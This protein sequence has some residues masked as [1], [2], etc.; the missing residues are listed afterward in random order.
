MQVGVLIPQ[1]WRMDLADFPDDQTKFEAMIR[2]AQRAEALGFESLWLYDHFHTTPTPEDEA[3]FECFTSLA[4]IARETRRIRLGQL[5]TCAWYRPPSLL[6]K[7][8]CTLDVASGGRVELGL[9]AG[10]YEHEFLAYGYG[11]PPL[12]QRFDM[13]RDT[14][15]ICRAMFGPGR[16]TFY[17]ERWSVDGAINE[18]KPLQPGGIPILVGGNGEKVTWRICAEYADESNVT[19]KPPE[20]IP[21]I[22]AKQAAH[23]EAVGR[24]PATLRLSVAV[25]DFHKLSPAQAQAMLEAYAEQGVSRVHIWLPNAATGEGLPWLAGICRAAHGVEMGAA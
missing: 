15:Q 19:G 10:W 9:G 8:V 25:P 11:F 22:R 13:L 18:P 17:G 12:R 24:D 20:A 3:V 14:L 23:C 6:A 7:I 1:G 4:A 5:V 21:D 2:A 16:A